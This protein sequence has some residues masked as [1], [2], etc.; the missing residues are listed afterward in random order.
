[1]DGRR[2]PGLRPHVPALAENQE[3]L[4]T[5]KPTARMVAERIKRAEPTMRN[6]FAFLANALRCCCV[7]ETLTMS[8][9]DRHVPNRLYLDWKSLLSGLGNPKTAFFSGSQ[10]RSSGSRLLASRFPLYS[11]SSTSSP[12]EEAAVA[13]ER[14]FA[15]VKSATR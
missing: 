10:K 8:A 15:A 12:S 3:G 5:M 6:Q 4:S 11:S 14:A 2:A 9:Q 7:N 13:L 1:M